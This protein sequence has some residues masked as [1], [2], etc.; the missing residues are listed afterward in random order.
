MKCTI[1]G[2]NAPWAIYDGRIIRGI[3]VCKVNTGTIYI[4]LV[5]CKFI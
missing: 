2:H 1:I 5:L 4:P 3:F